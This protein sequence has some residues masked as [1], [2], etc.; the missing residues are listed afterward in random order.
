M[1]NVFIHGKQTT[2]AYGSTVFDCLT[3]DW[4]Q[5][6]DKADITHTGA[7]G[8]QVVLG[9]VTRSAVSLTFVYDTANKPTVSPQ[10]FT[11]GTVAT[12]HQKPDGVDD[13][14][15]AFLITKLSWKGGPN[16][17]ALI[18]SVTADSTGVISVPAS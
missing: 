3:V 15:A 6:V 5:S 16:A 13:F 18:C 4:D 7:L 8:N 11:P 2:F 14:S 12:L 10:Q 17:G 9:G 1:P